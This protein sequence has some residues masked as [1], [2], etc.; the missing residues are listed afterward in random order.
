MRVAEKQDD[1]WVVNTWLKEAVLLF[2]AMAE[3]Q[4]I[5]AGPFEYLDKIPLKKG[6]REAGVR[7]VPPGTIRHGAFVERGAV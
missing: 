7:V 1:Q 5:E 3:M 4:V 6:L 2:F